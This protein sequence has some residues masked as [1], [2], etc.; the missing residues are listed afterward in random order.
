VRNVALFL[1]L[2]VIYVVF[3]ALLVAMPVAI[4]VTVF[5]VGALVTAPLLAPY[6]LVVA[7]LPTRWSARRRRATAL[8]TSPL[9]VT[10]FVIGAFFGGPG[11]FLLAVALPGALAYGGFVRL[12]NDHGAAAASRDRA[13]G[14]AG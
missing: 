13:F 10:W 14:A 9:L 7:T 5:V 12:H 6:L 4:G 8:A 2:E 3:L 11:P 1:A